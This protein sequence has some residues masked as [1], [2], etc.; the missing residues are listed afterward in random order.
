MSCLHQAL[1]FGVEVALAMSPC[2]VSDDDPINV[3]IKVRGGLIFDEMVGCLCCVA[4]IHV[5]HVRHHVFE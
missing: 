3:H 1:Y 4:Q 2:P 5:F